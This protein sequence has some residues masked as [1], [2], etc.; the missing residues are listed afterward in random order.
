MF[1][2]GTR[3]VANGRVRGKS[4]EG[5]GTVLRVHHDNWCNVRW[6][7]PQDGMHSCAGLCER[8]HGWNGYAADFSLEI[9]ENV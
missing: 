7:I 6:D 8:G 5:A 4:I 3:V 1:A 9:M 2:V